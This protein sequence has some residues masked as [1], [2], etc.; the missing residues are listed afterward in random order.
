MPSNIEIKA[1]V[2]DPAAFLARAREIAGAPEEILH[3]KDTFFR[4]DTGRLK[5][6]EF[7]DGAG[8]LIAY[9]RPDREKPA[10]SRYA[11]HPTGDPAG[12]L[13]VLRRALPVR[14]IVLKTRFLLLAG[15]TR[16]HLDE[17]QD[18]GSFMELEVVLAEGDCPTAGER[19]AARLMA[20]L[21]VGEEDLVKEAYIDLLE[22]SDS[23]DRADRPSAPPC[24]S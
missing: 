18:L 17:V 19:E 4:V 13:S 15:R 22:L 1:R 2:R 21:G 7:P 9:L 6:R 16:I 11:I 24:A 20:A 10:A 8:E 14:G 23:K 3:Q 5:L 12:L